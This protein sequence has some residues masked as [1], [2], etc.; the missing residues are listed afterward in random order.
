MGVSASRFYETTCIPASSCS[1]LEIFCVD[2]SRFRDVDVEL[3]ASSSRAS[4]R[5]CSTVQYVLRLMIIPN[6]PRWIVGR[7]SRDLSDVVVLTT[8]PSSEAFISRTLFPRGP[9]NWT[10]FSVSPGPRLSAR[11]LLVCVAEVFDTSNR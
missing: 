9:D 7:K 10:S 11:N 5:R 2:L 4:R 8:E 1:G 6:F 3:S